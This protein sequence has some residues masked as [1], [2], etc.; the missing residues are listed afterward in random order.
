MPRHGS[1]FNSGIAYPANEG[2]SL[3]DRRYGR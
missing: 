1:V 2:V 3:G